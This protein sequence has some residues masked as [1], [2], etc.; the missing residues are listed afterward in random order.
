MPTENDTPF[1]AFQI[2]MSRDSLSGYVRFEVYVPATHSNEVKA[3]IC[4]AGA[5]K[6]GNYDSCVWETSGTGQ[7]RPLAGSN[8]YLGSPN[9]IERVE[10]VKLECICEQSKIKDVIAAMKKAHPYETAAFSYWPVFLE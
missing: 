9:E 10:E 3:A 5:G 8:P 6:L 7:F 1:T 4:E 2:L